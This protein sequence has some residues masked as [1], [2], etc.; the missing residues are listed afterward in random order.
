[1]P[2]GEKIVRGL[3]LEPLIVS[4]L[5]QLR[6]SDRVLSRLLEQRYTVTIK[7]NLVNPVGKVVPVLN[8]TSRI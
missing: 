5:Q 2:S 1:M 3:R 4:K 6:A 7:L 8:L